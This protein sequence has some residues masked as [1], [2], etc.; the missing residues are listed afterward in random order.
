[1]RSRNP[2]KSLPFDFEQTPV[3]GVP[4]EVIR[5]VLTLP[6]EVRNWLGNFLLDSTVEG[7]DGMPE[8][9]ARLWKAEL[10]RRIDDAEAHPEKLLTAEQMLQH[11]RDHIEQLRAHAATG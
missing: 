11:L 6:N 5:Y 3:P 10:M 1:M 2:D 9:S 4:V 7:F 8:T